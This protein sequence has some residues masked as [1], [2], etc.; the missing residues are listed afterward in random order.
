M[1]IQPL[2]PS[3]ASQ[4]RTF[5]DNFE[6]GNGTALYRSFDDAVDMTQAYVGG[7]E[8]FAG[9]AIVTFTDGLDNGSINPRKRIGSK[10]AYFNHIKLNVLNKTIGNQPF[11]SYTIFVP[12]GADVKDKA[13]EQQI[14]DEL[15]I[16]AKQPDRFFRVNNTSELDRQFRYIA[17]SLIDSWKVLSCFI[18]AGQNGQVCWTFGKKVSKPAPTPTP[19]PQPVVRNGRN[20]FVGLNGTI[21]FPMTMGS[22]SYYD[23]YYGYTRYEDIFGF[24]IIAKFGIDFAYPI[25]DRFAMGAY[26]NIGGGFATVSKQNGTD[27]DGAF[28]FK[29]GLLMLAGDV[30]DR[31]FIIGISPCLGFGFNVA[32]D[33][34]P[35]E[36]RFGRVIKKHLYITGNLNMGIP[37]NGG[38]VLEPGLSIG[39]HFGDNLKTR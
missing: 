23:P 18:S 3:S 5:I 33:Y 22:N 19:A 38:F 34:M 4:M 30:N 10:K 15:T 32:S 14:T 28:D 7:L 36:V 17:K 29:V 12:G 1:R 39:Y 35:I 6:Q 31:P 25:T 24:G 27:T 16:M 21:G 20:I 13:D 11:Q 2:T 37:L 9:A 26:M 8:N